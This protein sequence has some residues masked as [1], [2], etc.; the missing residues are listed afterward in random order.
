M[1]KVLNDFFI[2][3]GTSETLKK[4]NQIK[5]H[6]ADIQDYEPSYYVHFVY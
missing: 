4:K 5:S 1:R 6:E 2:A 3:T